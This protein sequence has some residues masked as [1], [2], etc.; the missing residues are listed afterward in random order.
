MEELG[1]GKREESTSAPKERKIFAQRRRGAAV[2]MC[3]ERS[4]KRASLRS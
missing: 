4:E 1:I 3:A 2:T